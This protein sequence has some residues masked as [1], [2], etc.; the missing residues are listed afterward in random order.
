MHCDGQP[1]EAELRQSIWPQGDHNIAK[2]SNSLQNEQVVIN[3]TRTE[4]SFWTQNNQS[5]K[6]WI[7]SGE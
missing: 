7:G 3:E 6:Y 1:L 5:N 2:E 4:S